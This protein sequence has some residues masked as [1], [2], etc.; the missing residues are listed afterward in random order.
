M[1]KHPPPTKEI[2][3]IIFPYILPRK[4]SSLLPRNY[5]QFLTSNI[6]IIIINI[7]IIIQHKLRLLICALQRNPTVDK[8]ISP[9]T[10]G[11]ALFQ[12]D[13]NISIVYR[14]QQ[15][16]RLHNS[17]QTIPFY[18]TRQRDGITVPR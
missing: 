1:E 7:I 3:E 10:T 4:L 2:A 9:A 18:G 13:K 14:K 8:I 5:H 17:V 12:L 16:D 11:Y 6:I 15:R